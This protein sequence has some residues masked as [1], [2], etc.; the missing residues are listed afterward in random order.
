MRRSSL[1]LVALL[2]LAGCEDDAAVRAEQKRKDA[3]EKAVKFVEETADDA[4]QFSEVMKGAAKARVLAHGDNERLKRI[5]DATDRARTARQ[6]Q[7]EQL[8]TKAH[9]AATAAL[10]VTDPQ[11]AE[12]DCEAALKNLDTLAPAVAGRAGAKADEDRKLL[13]ERIDAARRANE[14]IARAKDLGE[15]S[16]VKARAFVKSFDIVPSLK[17]SPFHDKVMAVLST[18]PDKPAAG[19]GGD[20]SGG[21]GGDEILIFDGT[22]DNQ[23]TYFDREHDWTWKG[24]KP[25]EDPVILGDNTESNSDTSSIWLGDATWGDLIVDVQFNIGDVGL[26]FHV[27]SEEKEG[28]VVYDLV[29]LPDGWKKGEWSSVRIELRGDKAIIRFNGQKSEVSLA[30]K[31]GRFGIT[32]PP[33]AQVKIRSVKLRL[34]D[35]EAT[36]PKMH[37][38]KPEEDDKTDDMK[39]KKKKKKP[40]AG[41]GGEG[42]EGGGE[43]GEKK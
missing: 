36:R 18:I 39:K 14:V 9:E 26:Q 40:A 37:E 4:R 41:E 34:L 22:S 7:L 13:V 19:G 5:E 23:F 1:L 8:W 15:E 27:R 6:N 31:K 24:P 11:K 17:A 16:G 21:G 33:M 35:K 32:L 30:Q 10:A 12:K 43:G 42:G 28:N 38:P 25:S 3:A 2:A 20:S 29:S